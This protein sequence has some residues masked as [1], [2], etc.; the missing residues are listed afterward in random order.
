MTPLEVPNKDINPRAKRN[1]Q[2]P[3]EREA[4]LRHE[5]AEVFYRTSRFPSRDEFRASH[6]S[7]LRTLN[8]LESKG[9]VTRQDGRYQ[10]QFRLYYDSPFWKKDSEL[11]DAILSHLK[12]LRRKHRNQTL[13]FSAILGLKTNGCT[14]A[15]L[16]RVTH[17]LS[18]LNLLFYSQTDALTHDP[19]KVCLSED[20]LMY[21]SIGDRTAEGLRDGHYWMTAPEARA[22]AIPRPQI[23][24]KMFP[25]KAASPRQPQPSGTPDD[26]WDSIQT[27]FQISKIQFAKKI[28]FAK[29]VPTR[30]AIL[31]DVANAY[32][33]LQN[34]YW[35]PAVILSGGVIEELLRQ[36]LIYKGR[37]PV[38]EGFYGYITAC[39]EYGLL[40]SA[41]VHLS[42]AVKDFRNLVHLKEESQHKHAISTATATGAVAA[43]F[44]IAND[45]ERNP[46]QS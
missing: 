18:M 29:G 45:F 39:R 27:R 12:D 14:D 42:G 33:C 26:P 28:F 7:D 44:S 37:P 8:A 21:S 20:L 17:L 16:C 4:Q 35:K 22:V 13:D 2:M 46:T 19:I 9:I 1:H 32:G 5:L 41:V 10:F 25:Q 31:R 40:K 34:G 36:Y 15:D 6:E 11:I 23:V 43:I 38:K 3:T 30:N 24:E